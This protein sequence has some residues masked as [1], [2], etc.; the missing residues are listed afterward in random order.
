M[1]G[2]NG[3]P[4]SPARRSCPVSEA[5]H[6]AYARNVAS[7]GF[8]L[9]A[10]AVNACDNPTTLY[11]FGD[12]EREQFLVLCTKLYSLIESGKIVPRLSALAQDDLAFQRFVSRS[13]AG[14]PAQVEDERD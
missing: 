8:A 1:N 4:R 3:K 11:R 5:E 6:R 13:L 10:H 9:L 7:R 2:G 14:D 12:A